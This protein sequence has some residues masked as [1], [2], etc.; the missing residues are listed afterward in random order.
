VLLQPNNYWGQVAF[1]SQSLLKL[2]NSPITYARECFGSFSNQCRS[3]GVLCHV[4]M[5]LC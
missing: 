3:Y 4:L 2:K 5:S 1:M